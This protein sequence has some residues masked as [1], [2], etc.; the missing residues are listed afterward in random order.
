MDV[1]ERQ[2]PALP[3]SGVV[4]LLAIISAVIYQERPLKGSRPTSEFQEETAVYGIEDV[5]ARLWQDPFAAVKRNPIRQDD[6]YQSEEISPCQFDKPIHRHTLSELQCQIQKERQAAATS[7]PPIVMAVMV[8]GGPYAESSEWRLRSRYAVVS[9]LGRADYV[10]KDSEHIGFVD[11]LK[12]HHCSKTSME[13]CPAAKLP[14]IIPYEWFHSV[15]KGKSSPLLVLWLDDNAFSET[16]L[17]KLITLRYLLQAED[18]QKLH[19]KILGPA[20]ST[21]LLAMVKELENFLWPKTSVDTNHS[22]SPKNT[23]KSPAQP[24]HSEQ[25]TDNSLKDAFEIYSSSATVSAGM[26]NKPF[27]M[28]EVKEPLTHQFQRIGIEF[29]RTI[30]NDW[31]LA[32]EL[33]CE[34]DRRGINAVCGPEENDCQ[35]ILNEQ[36]KTGKKLDFTTSDNNKDTPGIHPDHIVL[37]AEWDTF[38]GRSLPKSFECAVKDWHSHLVTKTS[39]EKLPANKNCETQWIHRFSYL[40][41]ID[42]QLSGKGDSKDAKTSQSSKK[43]NQTG[44]IA[45]D[46]EKQIEQIERPVGRG[47]FDYLHRL[48]R[49]I[50]RLQE[51]LQQDNE[52]IKAIGVLGSDVYD[53]LLILQAPALSR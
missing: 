33:I 1:P 8:F 9:A 23:V 28:L 49:Q 43:N 27:S 22:P 10:P 2:G 4:L 53:K 37:I 40:R 34:L 7:V 35:A 36:C 29:Y 31:D 19:F 48:S 25:L 13:D 3:L 14:R 21:N 44:K 41:G 32:L 17:K 5:P 15:D 24:E 46:R 47:Q 45:I 51:K 26:A 11:L 39:L 30:N 38:Y 6:T 18:N 20:G 16:P 52:E 50:H 42:G 12:D